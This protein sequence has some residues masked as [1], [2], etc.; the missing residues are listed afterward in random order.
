MR[1]SYLSSFGFTV[2]ELLLLI[3]VL[4]FTALITT[5][6]LYGAL[7][8]QQ[9]TSQTE[10]VVSELKSA[11]QRSKI[12]QD[13]KTFGLIFNHSKLLTAPEK[14]TVPLEHGIKLSEFDSPSI[15]FEKLSGF[16]RV[17]NKTR[18]LELVFESRLFVSIVRINEYGVIEVSKPAKKFQAH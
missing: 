14:R 7:E 2:L 1:N 13:G 8:K 16:P 3:S 15:Y 6:F 5:P 18:T 12:A 9:L 4:G 17:E 11:Q 10:K